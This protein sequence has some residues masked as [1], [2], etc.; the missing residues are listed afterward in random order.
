M[1]ELNI[2]DMTFVSGGVQWDKV[3]AGLGAVGIGLA[4]YYW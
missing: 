1:K 2:K 4:L 3:G